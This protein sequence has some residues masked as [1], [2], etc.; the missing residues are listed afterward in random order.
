[1]S[2][3]LLTAAQQ[4]EERTF[5]IAIGHV[6]VYGIRTAEAQKNPFR[7]SIKE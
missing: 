5:C 3:Q 2:K 4:A 6:G 7:S 1:M